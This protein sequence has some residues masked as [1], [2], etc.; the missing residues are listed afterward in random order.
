MV[1]AQRAAMA[2]RAPSRILV[3][4]AAFFQFCKTLGRRAKPDIPKRVLI[5]HHLLLGD[6]LMLTPLL[7]KL[8]ERFPHAEI[9]MTTPKAILA[10]YEKRP[11]GVRALPYDPTDARALLA[12]F[13]CTDFDLALIPGDNRLSWL[14]LA[15]GAKWI[16]A[17]AGDRP[18]YKNWPIDEFCS[19]PNSP[20]AW[21][22]IVAQLVPGKP[23]TAYNPVDWPAPDY[24]PF[25][26]PSE[27]YCV[28]HVGASSPLKF[29]AVSK[30]KQLAEGLEERGFRVVWSGVRGEQNIVS[31]IDPES[32]YLSYVGQ[33]DLGQMWHLLHKACL[34]IS[35]DTGIAH[36][37]R[38]VNTPTI[39]L[40]GPGS[41]ILSGAGVFWRYSPYQA[42][43]VDK[44]SCRNQTRIFKRDFSWIEICRRGTDKCA[45]NKCMQAIDFETVM[46]FAE[47][48][49]SATEEIPV[50]AS[51]A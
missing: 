4:A 13:K 46:E 31:A 19:Y 43:T 18:A 37:G 47:G 26:L 15:L 36:L 40:F 7:A 24:K 10:L 44:F 25:R 38:I 49:L 33:L 12:L 39:T 14:A 32:R 20:H 28:L 50:A 2:S 9:V 41:H 11:Y 21:G 1:R 23:P 48:M 5:A 30:W 29:W 22:D 34:L 3:F 45:L 27:P 35:P 51:G 8:R 17:F 6:T 16:V 42:V